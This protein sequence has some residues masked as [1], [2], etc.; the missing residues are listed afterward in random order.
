MSV[1]VMLAFHL[2]PDLVEEV[3][4]SLRELLPDT[5]AFEGCEDISVVQSQEDPNTLLIV[6][7][8]AARENYEAYF[9]WRTDTGAIAMVNDM[10]TE[11]LQPKY[12]DF[13]RV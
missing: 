11:P 2:K 6:E 4:T 12:Y 10:C 13:V 1:K 9:K 5:R 7:Q 3:K 8:W